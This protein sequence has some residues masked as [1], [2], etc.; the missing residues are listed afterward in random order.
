MFRS[1]ILAIAALALCSSISGQNANGILDGR[2]TDASGSSIP[3]AK[4]TV[5][6]RM[7]ASS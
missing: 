3:G 1:L 5:E 4:V 6:I 7:P 2:I